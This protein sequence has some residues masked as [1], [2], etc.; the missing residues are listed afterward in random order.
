VRK[1]VAK[2]ESAPAVRQAAQNRMCG[3]LMRT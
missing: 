2:K 3:L 1:T